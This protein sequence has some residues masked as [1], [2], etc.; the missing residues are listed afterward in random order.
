MMFIILIAEFF[1][2]NE[3]MEPAP[4]PKL[5]RTPGT[6]PHPYLHPFLSFSSLSVS[7]SLSHSFNRSFNAVDC[8]TGNMQLGPSPRIGE[9][10][11]SILQTLGYNKLDIDKMISDGVVSSFIPR[12][13]L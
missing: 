1:R 9:H 7:F 5:S 6:Y 12:S 11:I 10:T 13:K 3:R 2:G 8:Q 4:A